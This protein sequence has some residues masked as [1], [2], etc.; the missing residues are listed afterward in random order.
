VYENGREFK[1][2]DSE[3]EVK[4]WLEINDSNGVVI[5][6]VWSELRPAGSADRHGVPMASE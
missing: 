4:A 3:Q 1:S 5:K 2:F 6:E